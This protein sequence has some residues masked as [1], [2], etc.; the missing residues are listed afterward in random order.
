MSGDFTADWLTLREPADLD[1]RDVK[2]LGRLASLCDELSIN[3]AVDL[4]CGTGSTWRAMPPALADGL[5]WTLAD[6]DT[7][8]LDE[9]RHRLGDRPNVRFHAMDLGDVQAIPLPKRGL[10]TASALFDLCSAGWIDAFVARIVESHAVLYAALTHDGA[11]SFAPSHAGDRDIGR[12]FEAHQRTDKGLGVALGPDAAAHLATRLGQAGMHVLE[13]RSD[14][15][16]TA[17]DAGLQRAYIDGYAAALGDDP[18]VH[19]ILDSWLS[20]R[21][22]AIDTGAASCIVGHRDVLAWPRG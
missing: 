17:R 18:S 3:E 22:S 11:V 2:L 15:V 6:R 9:A 10:V 5:R 14:W 16:L 12:A 1:A 4:G 7:R 8:L 21:F 19:G 13:A 20:H